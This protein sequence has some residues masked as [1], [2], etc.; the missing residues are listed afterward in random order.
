MMGEFAHRVN[1]AEHH[2]KRQASCRHQS[3]DK[4]FHFSIR[5]TG[6]TFWKR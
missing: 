6:V 2:Q 1:R 3:Y 5:N 4:Y